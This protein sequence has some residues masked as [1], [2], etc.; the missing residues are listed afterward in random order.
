VQ[1]RWQNQSRKLWISLVNF[2]ILTRLFNAC[3]TSEIKVLQSNGDCIAKECRA[4]WN[5]FSCKG[6]RPKNLGHVSVILGD[7]RPSYFTVKIWD[8]KFRKG[9]L[10]TEDER[11]VRPTRVTVPENVDVIYSMIMGDRIMRLPYKKIAETLTI[12]RK[13]GYF[14]HEIVDMTKL[15][16]KWVPKC[17]NANFGQERARVFASQTISEWFRRDPVGFLNSLVTT[18]Q[19]WIHIRV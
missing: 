15:S 12:S 5:I 4:W 18:D 8:T 19:T 11:S 2:V 10:S 14:I 16:T 17:L 3:W 1:Y 6:I 7:M 13:K 9:H